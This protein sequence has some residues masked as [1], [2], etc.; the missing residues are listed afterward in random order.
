MTRSIQKNDLSKFKILR[1]DCIS[2]KVLPTVF[3]QKLSFFQIFQI[4]QILNSHMDS[5]QWIDQNSGNHDVKLL[6]NS[7]QNLQMETLN[8]LT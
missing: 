2:N 7:K 4:T 1:C 5:L 6:I 3:Q 8:L